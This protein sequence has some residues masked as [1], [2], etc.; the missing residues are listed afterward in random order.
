[1]IITK[2]GKYANPVF[3]VL[4]LPNVAMFSFTIYGVTIAKCDINIT[5]Y[6][7]C[8]K[9]VGLHTYITKYSN[10]NIT[11]CDVT[12]AKCDVTLPKYGYDISSMSH[13][14]LVMQLS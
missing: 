2:Y 6:R 10:I 12:I 9:H 11:I 1:M 13:A 14:W 3:S 8:D 7:K 5:K 4:V